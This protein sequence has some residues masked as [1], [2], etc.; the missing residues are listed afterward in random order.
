MLAL[1]AIAGSS[2]ASAQDCEWTVVIENTVPPCAFPLIVE[3]SWGPGPVR[4]PLTSPFTGFDAPGTYTF[5]VPRQMGNPMPFR[6]AQISGTQGG[7]EV[8]GKLKAGQ[9]ASINIGCCC[10]VEMEVAEDANGCITVTVREGK[11]P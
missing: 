11:C 4:I 6:D 1:L 7:S 2:R 10:C 9:T 3:S 8:G 5:P